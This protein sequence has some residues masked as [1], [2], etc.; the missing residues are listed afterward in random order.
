VGVVVGNELAHGFP[1]RICESGVPNKCRV[2]L[3]E[4]IIDRLSCSIED[5]LDDAKPFV[6]RF[7]QRVITLLALAQRLFDG[8]VSG[9]VD[10]H[11][12]Q[13]YNP[14]ILPVRRFAAPFDPAPLARSIANAK[15]D[16]IVVTCCKGCF[17]RVCDRRTVVFV[18]VCEERR[19]RPLQS[20][21]G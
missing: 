18:H 13:G 9:D 3:D 17:Y 7:K 19:I 1:E 16:Y 2:Y 10:A 5:Y 14:P 8:L 15:F 21:R 4:A 12:V 11:P 20:A 6:D